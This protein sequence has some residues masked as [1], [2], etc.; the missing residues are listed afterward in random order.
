VLLLKGAPSLVASPGQPVLV[1]S[2]G[3]SDL[4]TAGMGDVLSGV[5]GAFLAQGLAPAPAAAL[6]L[7]ASGRAARLAAKGHGLIPDDVTD[8]LPDALAERG[9]GYSE[10]TVSGLL[11]DQDPAH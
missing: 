2:V 1:D 8:L 5:A 10:L 9:D 3:S 4:A 6:A 11:F 7:H